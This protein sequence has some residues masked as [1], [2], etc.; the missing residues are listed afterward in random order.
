MLPALQCAGAP[1][2]PAPSAAI[3]PQ[4]SSAAG[5]SAPLPKPTRVVFSVTT[6]ARRIDLIKDTLDAIV[7]QQSHPVDR[8]YLATPPT[9]SW[10]RWL[11]EYNSTSQR[12][13]VLRCLRMAKDYGPASKL[14]A[15]LREGGERDPSTVVIWG[16]DDVHYGSQLV[17]LHL[18]AQAS[19]TSMTAFAPRLITLDSGSQQTEG[20]EQPDQQSS[21]DVSLFRSEHGIGP[22]ENETA[23]MCDSPGQG[24]LGRNSLTCMR[25]TSLNETRS[26]APTEECH[27]RRPARYGEWGRLC[28]VPVGPNA[29][30]LL[31]EGTG[32]VSVRASVASALPEAAYAVGDEPDSCRLSDDYWISHYLRSANV[33]LEGLPNCR[34]DFDE[35]RYDD[36]CG[37]R[38]YE[39]PEVSWID[40][41]S[42]RGAVKSDSGTAEVDGGDFTDQLARY[43][44]CRER[45]WG[46]ELRMRGVRS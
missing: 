15:A 29:P 9:V 41:L 18:A 21:S 3:A 27:S 30:E 14:F 11:R 8:V 24:M 19:A 35:E 12:P 26:C 43:K 45:V 42:T 32:T 31:V 25:G 7:E 34:F 46:H 23:C 10:P 4:P 22:A 6:T 40:A 17:E 37:S 5:S 16:D 28:R 13:G 39:L 36:A 20:Q 1:H 44:L 2:G 38:F 33:S